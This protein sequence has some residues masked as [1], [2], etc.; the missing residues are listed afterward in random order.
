MTP[1]QKIQTIPLNFTSGSLSFVYPCTHTHTL[2]YICKCMSTKSLTHK[3][4]FCAVAGEV[5]LIPRSEM[6][7]TLLKVLDQVST[8]MQLHA[9]IQ[10]PGN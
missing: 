1:H 2:M 3:H 5:V 10:Y 8:N 4:D 9:Q 6:L 7:P